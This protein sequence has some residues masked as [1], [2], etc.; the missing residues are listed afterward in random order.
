[1]TIRRI[2]VNTAIAFA[3]VLLVGTGGL[4]ACSS[5][6]KS[7]ASGGGSPTTGVAVAAGGTTRGVTATSITV[8]GLGINAYYGDAAIGAQARFAAQNASGGVYGRKINFIGFKD[9][10]AS[11][12][13]NTQVGKEL[14]E[15]DNVFAVVPVITTVLGAGQY[16]GQQHVPFFGWGI[17]PQFENDPYAF[18]FNGAN[19]NPVYQ[20]TVHGAEIAQVLGKSP[21]NLTLG[22]IGEDSTAASQS[23]APLRYAM[24]SI[25]FNVVYA[26]SPLPTAPAVVGD[27]TPFANA[28]MTANH[29]QP[30]DAVLEVI[31]PS[32]LGL[33]PAMQRAGYKG[34]LINFIQYSPASAA[35]AKGIYAYVGFAPATASS[36]PGVAQMIQEVHAISPNAP[37]TQ[38]VESGWVSADLFVQALK[39]AGKNLTAEAL[40]QAASKMTY[41]I[42]NMVGPTTWPTAYSQATSCGVL[43]YSNGSEWTLAHP[44]EC[45]ASV[46]Y[47]GG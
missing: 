28:L 11:P 21:K 20:I 37:I 19:T 30:P 39:A 7:N 3:A 10:Q 26:A 27:Y 34:A 17:A 2:R 42:P 1:M 31:G 22:I 35:Q 47:P 8:G 15:Q 33:Q 45:T 4:A 14:V 32:N 9:D 40:Q 18:A 38:T 36:T 25:G 12:T 29:G 13:V 44:Y 23:I 16:F 6:T 41:E 5:S 46:K 43:M 24:Q